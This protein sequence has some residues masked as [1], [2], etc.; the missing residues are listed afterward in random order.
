M[1]PDVFGVDGVVCDAQPVACPIPDNRTERIVVDGVL[2]VLT[3]HGTVAV[4]FVA[5][6]P[7]CAPSA[8]YGVPAR[9]ADSGCNV[10]HDAF[11]VVDA[12]SG[13]DPGPP[14]KVPFAEVV[15]DPFLHVECGELS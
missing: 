4:H 5:E 8:K 6:S 3:S 12:S 10:L 1:C 11:D 15:A 7:P 9:E 13:M 14:L 2:L